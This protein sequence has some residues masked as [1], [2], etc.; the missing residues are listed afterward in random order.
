MTVRLVRATRFWRFEDDVT[1]KISPA[2]GGSVVTAQSQSRVG[3]GDLGQ[4]P[5]NLIELL[6][7]VRRQLVCCQSPPIC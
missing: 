6:G 4:N 3:K 1:V 7:E 2:E 5:R